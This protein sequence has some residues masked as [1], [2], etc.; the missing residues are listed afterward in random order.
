MTITASELRTPMMR[1]SMSSDAEEIGHVSAIPPR[2]IAAIRIPT[3]PMLRPSRVAKI[4]AMPSMPPCA[5]PTSK[6]V[7]APVG[8]IFASSRIVMC[9]LFST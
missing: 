9:V 4:T 5:R 8:T 2:L 7:P 1:R 3:R 6:M